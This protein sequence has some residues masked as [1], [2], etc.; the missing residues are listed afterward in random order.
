LLEQYSNSDLAGFIVVASKKEDFRF[1]RLSEEAETTNRRRTESDKENQ[2]RGGGVGGW[3]RGGL[4][5]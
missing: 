4:V 3:R 2:E 1:V 5:K